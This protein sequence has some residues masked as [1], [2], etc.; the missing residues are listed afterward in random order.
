ANGGPS[1]ATVFK[2]IE[3]G[4][5]IG[6]AYTLVINPPVISSPATADVNENTPLATVVLDVDATDSDQPPQTLT[7]SLSGPDHS[8]FSIDATTGQIRFVSSP[9]FENPTDSDAN[10][11]YQVTVSV[12]DGTGGVTTQDLTISVLPLNDNVPIISSTNAV[13][14]DENTATST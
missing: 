6:Q 9:D 13:S 8:Q 2:N 1:G 7:Y 4:D 11:S 14:V 12:A 3:N 10:N 5:F